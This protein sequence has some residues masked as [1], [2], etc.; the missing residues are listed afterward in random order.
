MNKVPKKNHL[1]RNQVTANHRLFMADSYKP[2]RGFNLPTTFHANVLDSTLVN[3]S[4]QEYQGVEIIEHCFIKTNGTIARI[5]V[6][7][8]ENK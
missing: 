6:Y 1:R 2:A 8:P 4:F 3:E 7:A 5:L